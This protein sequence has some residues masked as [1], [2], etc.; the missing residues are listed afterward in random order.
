L[1]DLPPVTLLAL[2]QLES[3]IREMRR[4]GS[5]EHPKPHKMIML[6]AV[7][8]LAGQGHLDDNRIYL[9]Q[10]LMG[11]FENCFRQFGSARDWCLPAEPFFHLRSAPFWHHKVKSGREDT[12]AALTTSGGG[13]RRIQENIEYAYLS[14][15]AYAV[16][17]HPEARQELHDFIVAQPDLAAISTNRS[18]GVINESS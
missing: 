5:H 16:I 8:E 7:L 1:P 4:G 3:D 9:D 11:S 14:N 18:D 2:R 13:V 15:Y 12:Y 17:H 10:R 6:L